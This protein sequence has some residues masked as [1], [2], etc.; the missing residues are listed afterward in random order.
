MR[1]FPISS[2]TCRQTAIRLS[3]SPASVSLSAQPGAGD[4]RVYAKSHHRRAGGRIVA[5]LHSGHRR[6]NLGPEVKNP[7]SK[8]DQL[9]VGIVI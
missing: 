5:A 6:L 1:S 9:G 7:K 4:I 8:L 2:R 3:S